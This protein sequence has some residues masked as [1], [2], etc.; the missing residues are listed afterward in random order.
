MEKLADHSDLELIKMT[1]NGDMSAFSV[2]VVRYEDSIARTIMGM[3][4]DVP[5]ADDIGQE[6]FIRFYRSLNKFKGESSLKTYLTRIAINLT[7][8][9][10]KREKRILGMFKRNERENENM[11]AIEDQYKSSDNRELVRMA[12]Q[13][14]Q[15]QFRMVIVLRIMEG[16][17]TKET[18][19][20]LKIPMGTVL[21]R[22]ARA[23]KQLKPILEKLI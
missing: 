12:L 7:L 19:K 8:N 18:A 21:S 3:I 22:L 10:I 14:L 4:G 11:P 6:V 16:Y 13:H 15:P 23:Q 9:E 5:V 2:I 17:S 1:M 20:I